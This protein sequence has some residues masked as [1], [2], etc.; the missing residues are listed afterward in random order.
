[1][2]L[3]LVAAS[4]ALAVQYIIINSSSVTASSTDGAGIGGGGYGASSV[5]GITINSSSVTASS[6]NGAGIGGGGY[7]A[8]SVSDI[9][10]NSSSVTASST[11]GAGIGSAGGTCSNIGISGGSVKAYSDRMPGINCTP[12]NGNSTNVY[13]CI[14]KNEYLFTSNDR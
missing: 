2:V 9:T 8:D 5:S 10:I 1:M 3:E 11:N 7:G 13:C 4:N 12:H 6:T 14:I